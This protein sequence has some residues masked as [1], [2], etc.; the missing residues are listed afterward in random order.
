MKQSKKKLS[1]LTID[2]GMGGTER[3]ISLL[4]PEL[5]NHFEVTLVI[6]YKYIDYDIPEDVNL[7]ILKPE[8]KKSKSYLFK[9]KNFVSLYLKYKRFIKNE[10]IDI[11]FSLLPIP[12][13]IN[14]FIHMGLKNVRTVISERCYPSVMYKD[15]HM[16]LKLAKLFFPIFYNRNDALFSNSV[17]INEDLK[18]NFGVKIPMQVIYNPI[19]TDD[20]IKINSSSFKKTKHLKLINA[21][22]MYSVKNQKLIL[23]A[24]SLL[25]IGDFDFTILGDGEL[26]ETLRLQSKN[27]GLNTNFHQLGK[28]NDIKAHLIQHDCFILSSDTEGFPNVLLEAL[29]VG[30]PV[31]STN[32][33]SGPLEMLNDNESVTIKDG[34]FIKAKYGIL[35]NVNDALGMSKAIQYYLE[36]PKERLKYSDL[37]FKRAKMYNMPKIYNQMKDILTNS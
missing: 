35:V 13:I 11:S 9:I 37:A 1:I 12:N 17:H 26:A 6:F 34:E 24:M 28:V 23:D 5:K 18:V 14:S 33:L 4:L 15:K 25:Q 22:T 31:I 30:L 3:F 29:S 8:T 7:L 19:T 10:G 32:C 21:G 27:L 16:Q 20:T 36:H 2:Y